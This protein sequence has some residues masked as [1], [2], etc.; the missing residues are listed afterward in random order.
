M[1]FFY[2]CHE[3]DPPGDKD[4]QCETRDLTLVEC[5]WRVGNNTQ[6][7][8]TRKRYRLLGRYNKR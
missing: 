4:L 6:L 1:F 3:L 7:P 2:A 5:H 8:K